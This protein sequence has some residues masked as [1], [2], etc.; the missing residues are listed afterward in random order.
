MERL[1]VGLQCLCLCGPRTRDAWGPGLFD[2]KC[3]G[4]LNHFCHFF[5]EESINKNKEKTAMEDHWEGGYCA[6]QREMD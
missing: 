4:I 3:T 1:Q 2:M 5:K 6:T